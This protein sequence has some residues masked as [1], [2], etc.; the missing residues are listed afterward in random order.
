MPAQR[1]EPSAPPQAEND[2]CQRIV[3][4][5]RAT[6]RLVPAFRRGMSLPYGVRAEL[7]QQI[8]NNSVGKAHARAAGRAFRSAAGGE[9]RV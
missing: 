9:R 5:L 2:M 4:A 6:G 7:L 1:D 8:N 3:V